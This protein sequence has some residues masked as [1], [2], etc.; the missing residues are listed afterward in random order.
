MGEA[1]SFINYYLFWV[2]YVT[3][4]QSLNL[5]NF[6]K[7]LQH[8]LIFT[9]TLNCCAEQA[10][11]ADILHYH[12]SFSFHMKYFLC[13]VLL[14]NQALMSSWISLDEKCHINVI[15]IFIEGFQSCAGLV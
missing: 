14:V 5:G 1:G 12:V 10:K 2:F 4:S 7:T 8:Y 11:N 15:I 6:N 13:N 3:V 9:F